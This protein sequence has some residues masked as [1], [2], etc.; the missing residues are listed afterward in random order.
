MSDN[1]TAEE[2]KNDHLVKLGEELGSLYHG[3]WNELARLYSK[4]DEYVE[5]FGTKPSRLE[6]LNNSAPLFFRTVQESLWESTLIHITRITDPPKSCG[7]DNLSIT[8]L[9]FLVDEKLKDVI[10]ERIDV[11]I[12]KSKFCRDWRN[13]RIAHNDLSLA[14]GSGAVPLEPAS[15]AKIKDALKCI[16]SVLNTIEEHYMDSTMDFN[17]IKVACGAEALLYVLNDGLMAEKER[18]I[19]IENRTYT[20]VNDRPNGAT[21]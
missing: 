15:R 2:V 21:L 5:L 7:K 3:L 16:A 20:P 1:F 9:P 19:R 11:A 18:K 13:R 8:R 6:L 17:V 4:W 14:L 12:E 10:S